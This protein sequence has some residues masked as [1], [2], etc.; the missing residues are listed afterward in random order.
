MQICYQGTRKDYT[1][2]IDP[3]HVALGL[4]INKFSNMIFHFNPFVTADVTVCKTLEVFKKVGT[5]F[6]ICRKLKR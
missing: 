1:S 3:V 2:I 6:T 5:H 4:Y